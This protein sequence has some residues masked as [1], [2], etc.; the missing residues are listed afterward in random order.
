MRYDYECK[1][2][3]TKETIDKPMAES[4]R[5]EYCKECGELL[6]RIYSVGISTGDGY[7]G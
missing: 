6:S 2:C 3:S 4:S 1:E 5:E 7:K